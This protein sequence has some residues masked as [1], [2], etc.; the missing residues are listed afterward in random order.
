MS[1]TLKSAMIAAVW[2]ILFWAVSAEAAEANLR[3]IPDVTGN[4]TI[5]LD[6]KPWLSGGEYRVAGLSSAEGT[7]TLLSQV[8]TVVRYVLQNE[9]H[10]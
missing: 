8:R 7:L 3:V 2:F 9:S 5:T 6:G 10:P 4:F 1:L